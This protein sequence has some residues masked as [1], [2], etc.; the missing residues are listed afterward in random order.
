MPVLDIDKGWHDLEQRLSALSSTAHVLVGVQG[1]KGDAQHNDSD[2]TVAQVASIHEFGLGVP[3]RSFL[4]STMDEHEAQ[5]LQLA[6]RLGQGVIDG[7]F[8]QQQALGLLGE[9]GVGLVVDKIRSH[10]EPPNAPSTI[11]RKGS[12]TPLI[13]SAQLAQSIT[14]QVQP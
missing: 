1:P 8:S 14:A 13:D 6:S 9:K 5:L 10:I 12:D 7:R 4:R 2:L 3:E 11:K